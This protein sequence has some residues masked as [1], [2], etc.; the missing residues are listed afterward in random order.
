MA[1]SL[2]GDFSKD[3][4]TDSLLIGSPIL[5][6]SARPGLSTYGETASQKS[7]I[8]H[9]SVSQQSICLRKSHFLSIS[10]D[11]EDSVGLLTFEAHSRFPEL[12]QSKGSTVAWARVGSGL[13]AILFGIGGLV[14]LWACRRRVRSTATVPESEM[15]MKRPESEISSKADPFVS[16]ENALSADGKLGGQIELNNGNDEIWT[17]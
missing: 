5:V 17:E 13:V 16:E 10:M 14:F 9:I 1:E 3:P 4:I 2:G 8:P 12:D 15:E 6:P 7:L 11:F